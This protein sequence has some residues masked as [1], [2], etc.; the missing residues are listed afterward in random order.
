MTAEELRQ[1]LSGVKQPLT[2][3]PS[4]LSP[5]PIPLLVFGAVTLY[6]WG[7]QL[8]LPLRLLV[9]TFHELGHALTAL[10]TGGEVQSIRVNS[11]EGGLTQTVGGWQFLI[12]NGGYLGS[13]C[14]GL[15]ILALLLFG[16]NQFFKP[17]IEW[18]VFFDTSLNGLNVG[19]PVKVPAGKA[20]RSTAMASSPSASWPS[21][22]ETMCMTW[23]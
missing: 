19:A 18:V 10:L 16:G 15:L 13:L 3:K 17:K 20:A 4:H 21:T 1:R 11:N 6:F 12:L 7:N 14:F 23:E 22:F 9:V 5:G 8:F 2:P